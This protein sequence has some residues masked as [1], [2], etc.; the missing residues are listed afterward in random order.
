M[1]RHIANRIEEFLRC[2]ELERPDGRA[3]YAYRCTAEEFSSLAEE[4]SHT[5]PPC[6]GGANPAIRAFVLYAAEWW[7]R[8]YD[9]RQW[10]WEPLL[11]SIDWH[12]VHYPDLYGPIRDALRWW[13]PDR[14]PDHALG[15][16]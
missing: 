13:R 6:G 4:L 2:R 11:A 12:L 1:T 3:L 7:Q 16:P 5:D 9:G 8:R 15:M 14:P 10:A